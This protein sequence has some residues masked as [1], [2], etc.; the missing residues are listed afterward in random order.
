MNTPIDPADTKT[1]IYNGLFG[2]IED[3]AVIQNIKMVGGSVTSTK[4]A[5]A[6]VAYMNGGTVYNCVSDIDIVYG[7]QSG[8]VV[9][10]AEKGEKN[11]IKGCVNHTEVTVPEDKEDK[12]IF[13]GGVVGCAGNAEISYCVNYGT[14]TSKNSLNY[15]LAGGIVGMQGAS[16]SPTNVYN[17]MDMGVITSHVS[18]QTK[19]YGAG[20]ICGKAAHVSF[21]EIADCFAVGTYVCDKEDGAAGIAGFVDPSKLVT[22]DNLYTNAPKA[23]GIDEL[24]QCADTVILKTEEMKGAAGIAKMKLNSAWVAEADMFP[25]IDVAKIDAAENAPEIPAETT[26]ETTVA[27][28]TAVTTEATTTEAVTDTTTEAVTEPEETTA[29]VSDTDP[30][31][32]ITDDDMVSYPIVPT[33]NNTVIIV[34]LAVAIVADAVVMVVVM[35]SKKNG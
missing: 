9:G 14:V 15:S 13:L 31:A 27:T 17:C 32:V 19:Y 16:S 4:Y 18:E 34:I 29:P 33:R 35:R 24:Q 7:L 20:G 8:G 28:T 11:I 22:I 10:R 12:S 5:A 1:M 30:D 25:T 2:W 3:P 23:S 21:A 6:V 26:T